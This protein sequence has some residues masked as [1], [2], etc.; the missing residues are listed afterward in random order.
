MSVI[1]RSLDGL[2]FP[3]AAK[4]EPKVAERTGH[5][6]SVMVNRYRRR[7]RSWQLVELGPLGECI[8]ELGDDYPGNCPKNHLRTWRNW[9]THQIQVLAR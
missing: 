7:A 4:T 1:G 9:Q 8:F 5:T 6:T 2:F 3:I